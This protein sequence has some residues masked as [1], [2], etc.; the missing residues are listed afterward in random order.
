MICELESIFSDCEASIAVGG[1]QRVVLAVWSP[2]LNPI[3][4][5]G[6]LDTLNV[7]YYEVEADRDTASV[8]TDYSPA[9]RT[10]NSTWNI[11]LIGL[12][13]DRLGQI[14]KLL[15]NR[16]ILFVET[17]TG[18]LCYGLH[19]GLVAATHGLNTGALGTDIAGSKVSFRG[20]SYCPPAQLSAA[21]IQHLTPVA[22]DWCTDHIGNIGGSE[23][24][25]PY[26][27]CVIA[28][29]NIYEITP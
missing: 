20:T 23:A 29:W 24:V 5:A 15:N 26:A 11:N 6:L 17:A 13:A 9:T 1:V 10:Y 7:P 21:F 16:V 27:P 12:T 8:T 28:D 25:I 19:F 4:T 14:Q 2:F 18:W 3:F 22:P